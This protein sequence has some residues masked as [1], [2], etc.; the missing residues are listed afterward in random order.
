MSATLNLCYLIQAVYEGRLTHRGVLAGIISSLIQMIS[1]LD[2]FIDVIL[3]CYDSQNYVKSI[4]AV[5]AI[6]VLIGF[7]AFVF[8]SAFGATGFWLLAID[9][10]VIQAVNQLVIVLK[11]GFSCE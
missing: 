2:S 8:V 1:T 11:D 10:A 7:S 5:V 4:A 9:L 3:S 6:S